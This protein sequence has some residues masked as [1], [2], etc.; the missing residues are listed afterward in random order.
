MRGDGYTILD[1][2][3]ELGAGAR[4]DLYEAG[5]IPGAAFI[6]LDR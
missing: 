5:H 1:V 6:D 4:R 2:R 3:W